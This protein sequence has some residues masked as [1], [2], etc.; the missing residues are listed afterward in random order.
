[1]I[2][3]EKVVVV[4]VSAGFG[5]FPLLEPHV[6]THTGA[7]VNDPMFLRVLQSIPVAA[8]QRELN[9]ALEAGSTV[10]IE[11]NV[12]KAIFTILTSNGTQEKKAIEYSNFL[13][14]MLSNEALLM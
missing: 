6:V 4:T 8:V 1:M 10:T 14:L 5:P 11:F 7:P 13:I 3:L 2:T 12:N 9:G